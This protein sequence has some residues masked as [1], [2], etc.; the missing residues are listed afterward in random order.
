MDKQTQIDS[1]AKDII[2]DNPCP[3]LAANATQLVMGS[4]SPEARIVLIGEAP[5]KSEDLRGEAFVGASGKFLDIM[6]DSI[7]LTRQDVYITN[8]VKYRPANNRDPS[9]LEK[10]AFGPYLKRQLEIIDPLVIATLGR[11]AMEFFI[12]E[13][14]IGQIHGQ[15][16][17]QPVVYD[18]GLERDWQIVPLYHPAAALYN[19]K[20]RPLLLEDFKQIQKIID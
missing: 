8:I 20:M 1:L 12:P 4:G 5:G 14:K 6:L 18:S 10:Q 19:G 17:S 9:R 11:H 2:A 7:G 16:I 13:A 15:P 3:E